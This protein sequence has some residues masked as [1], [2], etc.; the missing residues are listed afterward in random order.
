MTQAPELDVI[1]LGRSSVDLYGQQIGGRLE[2]M[3][4][5]A[6]AVGGSPANIAIGAARLGLRAG[7]VTRVGNEA[8][9]RFLREQL[10]REGVDTAMV[11]TDPARLTALAI[12]GVRDDHSFP[13]LFYRENCADMALSIA[14]ITPAGIAR[15]AAL[16]V[17]GT[18]LSTPGVA[19]ASRAAIAAARAAG[20]RVALDIDYRP[21]LWGLAHLGEG[22]ERY[23]ASTRVT[24]VMQAIL[25]DCDL[26]VGT[27]EEIRI[28]GGA[29]DVR[30]ALL[31]IRARSRAAIVLK[32]GPMGCVVFEGAI[33]ERLEDGLR[34]QG[35]P[36][37]V[38]NV[39]GAGDAFMAGFLRGWLRGED[40]RT[41]CS[42]ANACGAF[43][44][45][46]LLCSPEYPSWAELQHFLG[47]GSAFRA[48]RK[49]PVLA[50]LHQATTRRPQPPF[51]M[52]M[53]IDHRP[54]L[55]ALADRAG[56]PHARIA[57]FK[58]LAVKA[59]LRVAAGRPGF[60]MLLDDRH[61]RE[62]LFEAE[63]SGL[64]IARP[65]EEPASRPL[66]FELDRNPAVTLLEWPVTHTAKCLCFYHPDDPPDVRAAQEE[67]L[68]AYHEACRRMGRECLV[69]I[70]AS[71]HGAL[72]RETTAAVMQ[73]LYDLGIRPDWWKLEAQ[74][75]D[76]AWAAIAR[77]IA[78]E[79]P[80]CRGVLL[81]GLE[82][83]LPV[84]ED[85]FALAARCGVV[86]G[87]AVGRSIFAEPAES[88]LAGAI[89]DEEAITRLARNFARLVEAWSRVQPGRAAA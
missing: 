5:F 6:K 18:H 67:T 38:Y 49:D 60:G 84:L 28:A 74:P 29:E 1:T 86:R 24:A 37:E 43:A 4:S 66:R 89:G 14:D 69:E 54:Q 21:N 15:A 81:L 58:R 27:E 11:A 19:G 75:D 78:A 62:A 71:R 41:C 44:V 22:E 8:F 36:I 3:A 57:A 88:W 9:G 76:A 48:L 2:D 51:V 34:G 47:Q 16:V 77:V 61:G 12:V 50:H 59:A 70:I 72:G 32:Q 45:S 52:A 55:E 68:L 64:W 82:A 42:W 30:A 73:R 46:R 79:D 17:T 31:A 25:P 10:E 56:A 80:L 39:L 7:L 35:F 26:I 53:A 40:W 85:A 63:G 33:P 87:F 13:L 83:P 65:V 23:I 20:R